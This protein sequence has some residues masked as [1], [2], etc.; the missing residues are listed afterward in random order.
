MINQ[1]IA[2]HR[3]DPGHES[4]AVHVVG[5]ERAV[6]L[7]K[8]LLSQIVRI[9]AGSSESIADVVDAPMIALDNFLPCG[10]V[11][12]NAATDQQSSHMCVFQSRT[13]RMCHGLEQTK[14][15]AVSFQP[16]GRACR[17]TQLDLPYANG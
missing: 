10:C 15:S 16:S 1:Q 11:A 8:N 17:P 9:V 6:H 3:R 7:N 14:L 5:I 12:R 4:A 2:R 13:P